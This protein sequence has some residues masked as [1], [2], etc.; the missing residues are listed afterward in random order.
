MPKY[1]YR[2]S[3]CDG[4]FE[5]RHSMTEVVDTCVLC[6]G[7]PISRVPSLSFNVSKPTN[8]GSLVREYIEDVKR[9]V[10]AEKRRLKEDYNG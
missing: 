8:A 4:E 5:A 9:D 6:S 1:N 3:E 10:Q 7:G 2:C